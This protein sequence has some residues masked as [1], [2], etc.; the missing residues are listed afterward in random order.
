MYCPNCGVAI[1]DS[2]KFCINCGYS[3]YND[4]PVHRRQWFFWLMFL[5]LPPV[6][7]L[8]VLSGDVYYPKNGAVKAFGMDNRVYGVFFSLGWLVAISCMIYAIIKTQ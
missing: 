4:V 7:I 6:A 3:S 5:I 1:E 8:I 2:T